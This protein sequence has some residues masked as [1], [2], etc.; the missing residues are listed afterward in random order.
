MLC[1]PGIFF[2]LF[3]FKQM[4]LRLFVLSYLCIILEILLCRVNLELFKNEPS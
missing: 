2:Y 3:F 4:V 1:P